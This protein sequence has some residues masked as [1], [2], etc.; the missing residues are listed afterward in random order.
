M[1]GVARNWLSREPWHVMCER[2]TYA[3][4]TTLAASRESSVAG[5]T[6][7]RCQEGQRVLGR[8]STLISLDL[9]TRTIRRRRERIEDDDRA[10]AA[11]T[12]GADDGGARGGDDGRPLRGP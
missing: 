10:D 8:A 6:S 4:S 9:H 12:G 5:L 2:D 7:P 3:R 1:A 11:G